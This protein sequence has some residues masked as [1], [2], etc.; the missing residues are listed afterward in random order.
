[1]ASQ[2]TSALAILLRSS[3]RGEGVLHSAFRSRSHLVCAMEGRWRSSA[4]QYCTAKE[5]LSRPPASAR[6]SLQKG[7]QHAYHL[8]SCPVRALHG[9]MFVSPYARRPSGP[10]RLA[11]CVSH[12]VLLWRVVFASAVRFP[13]KR[14]VSVHPIDVPAQ[15]SFQARSLFLATEAADGL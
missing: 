1:M 13:H 2:R 6:R 14:G 3:G 10:Q 12:V 9:E 7:G 5:C 8:H 11:V 4:G 15:D